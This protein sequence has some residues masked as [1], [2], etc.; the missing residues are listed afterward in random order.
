MFVAIIAM[1]FMMLPPLIMTTAVNALAPPVIESILVTG[2]D[3]VEITFDKDID[4]AS[5]PAYVTEAQEFTL[6]ASG[7]LGN[8][9]CKL[10]PSYPN[11][12]VLDPSYPIPAEGI[13]LVI[14]KAYLGYIKSTDGAFLNS[15]SLWTPYYRSAATPVISTQPS[16]VTVDFGGTANLSVAASATTG[17]LT[18]QWYSNSSNSET[19]GQVIT[20]ETAASFSVPTTTSGTTYYYCVITNTDNTAPGSKT[21][22]STTRIAKVVVSGATSYTVTFKDWDETVLKTDV[23]ASGGTA[24]PPNDPTRSGYTFSGW[25]K[26]FT[27]IT[28]NLTVYATYTENP[29]PSQTP[30]PTPV[31]TP[32]VSNIVPAKTTFFT[33]TTQLA[34][35]I[36]ALNTEADAKVNLQLLDGSHHALSPAVAQTGTLD[37]NGTAQIFLTLP[38]NLTPGTYYLA[39]QVV[40]STLA[41]SEVQITILEAV[42]TTGENPIGFMMGMLLMAGAV[43]LLIY[44]KMLNKSS[45]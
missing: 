31:P 13:V 23:G 5:V 25:D 1:L 7:S 24:T 33:G 18:Y 19:G 29:T 22:T 3:S 35:S 9:S 30:A 27:S 6:Y 4:P 8:M 38:V 45:C 14:Y 43:I 37:V 34:V 21:T 42:P 17:S 39:S 12:I 2:P 16:D 40:G 36:T 11:V 26:N 10:K 28:D 15:F 44:R 41:S 20:G 32:F